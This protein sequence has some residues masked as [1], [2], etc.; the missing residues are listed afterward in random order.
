M[1]VDYNSMLKS[2]RA[3]L[4]QY[5]VGDEAEGATAATSCPP[6]ESS[7]PRSGKPWKR[8]RGI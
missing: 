1:I 5:A 7:W 3:A 8:P 4:A 2:L 6:S